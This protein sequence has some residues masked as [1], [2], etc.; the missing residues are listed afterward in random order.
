MAKKLADDEY[1]PISGI[2]IVP[3]VDIILVVLIVFMVV[4]PFVTKPSIPVN[5]PTA[6]SGSKTPFSPFNIVIDPQGKIFLNGKNVS[7]E[8]VSQEA[9]ISLK[10]DER[11][12]AIISADKN[13]PHGRVVK[14]IDLIKSAG[15]KKFA[16]TIEKKR[17]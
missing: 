5:L 9:K 10:S 12:Q 15:I 2:N 13:V 8:E 7:D 11:T 14:I 3:F 17:K 16:I 4:A 1:A 6:K